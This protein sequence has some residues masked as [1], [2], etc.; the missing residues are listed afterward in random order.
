[1]VR[2][3][4]PWIG[5]T[6]AMPKGRMSFLSDVYSIWLREMT[7]YFRARSRVVISFIQPMAWLII[8]GVGFSASLGSSLQFAGSTGTTNYLDFLVPGLL[9]FMAILNSLTSSSGMSFMFDKQ[10]GFLKEILVAPVARSSILLGK[11]LGG[12]TTAMIQGIVVVVVAAFLG[13][14]LSGPLGLPAAFALVVVTMFFITMGFSELGMSFA[15]QV[16][17]IEGF[18]VVVVFL[19]LP[20]S[21]LSGALF[22]VTSLPG[23]MKALVDINPLTY[24]VDALRYAFTGLHAYPL[25]LD[26]GVVVG[27]FILMTIIGTLLFRDVH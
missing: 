16:E 20:L 10:F 9:G 27:F 21:F 5:E 15:S 3:S 4:V 26:F 23:W 11:A 12:T 18:Q 6:I 19:A 1:M 13:V 2:A 24:A 22:P 7:R 25:T 14:R 8:F 17:S